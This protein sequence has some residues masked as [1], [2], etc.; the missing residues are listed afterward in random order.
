MRIC[1]VLIVSCSVNLDKLSMVLFYF[2]GLYVRPSDDVV[3]Q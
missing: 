3:L 2:P 1:G